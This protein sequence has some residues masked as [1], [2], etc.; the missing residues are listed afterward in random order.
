MSHFHPHPQTT[1]Q[2]VGGNH[3]T[4]FPDPNSIFGV[5][6]GRRKEDGR[7]KGKKDIEEILL[8]P[9]C[10]ELK[11]AKSMSMLSQRSNF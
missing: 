10:K 4:Q 5:L 1:L 8:F 11:S 3:M 6:A 7:G 2:S 9:S